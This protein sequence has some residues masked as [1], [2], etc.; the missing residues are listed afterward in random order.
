MFLRLG[1][2]MDVGVG[3]GAGRAQSMPADGRMVGNPFYS[4]QVQSQ[5][6][7]DAAR[8]RDL[9]VLDD[10]GSTLGCLVVQG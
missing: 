3:E 7:L 6:L 10:K 8:P 5:F 2:T 1:S 4:E 9:P